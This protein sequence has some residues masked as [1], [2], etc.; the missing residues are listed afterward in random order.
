VLALAAAPAGAASQKPHPPASAAAPAAAS[1]PAATRLPGPATLRY[2]VSGRISGVAYSA[3]A[4]LQW[5]AQ[6]GRYEAAWSVGLPL[7]GTQT[8][9]SQ[10]AVTEAGL[11]PERYAE[12]GRRERA[13]TFD[14]GSRLIRFGAGRPDAALQPG[15]Q[16]RLS[17]TLQLGALLAAAPKRYP[18][19]A[20][21][22][23]QTAG[24]RGAEPWAWQVQPDETLTLAGQRLPSAHLRRQPRHAGDTRVD[25]WLA[26]SLDYLPVRL[27]LQQDNGDVVDQQ[28]QAID[29]Q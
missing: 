12:R 15:A 6:G 16:D 24:V 23:L 17:V 14:A 22:T 4:Q 9:S 18:P 7:L 3:D 8:Q 2:R 29:R 25:L 26:R 20:K 28:L 10:G 13:A 1:A 19:G 5:R 27:R 11:A 21:I